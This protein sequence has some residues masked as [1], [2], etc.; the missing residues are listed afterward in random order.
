MYNYELS[1]NGNFAALVWYLSNKKNMDAYK[2]Q[3]VDE[4]YQ[5][6]KDMAVKEVLKE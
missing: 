4:R 3:C 5:H 2:N 6:C 1:K